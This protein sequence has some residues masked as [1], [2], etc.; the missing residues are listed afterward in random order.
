MVFARNQPRGANRLL[1]AAVVMGVALRSAQYLADT[2][3][4]L[5]EIALVKG[6]L[7]LD[8]RELVTES[9]PFDQV[10]PIGFL[11]AQKGAIHAFGPS[12]SALRLIPFVSS[13]VALVVF[14][15]FVERQLTSVAALLATLLFATAA[16][17][18]AF[19]GTA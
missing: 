13:V 9:L 12:D 17:F 4:W 6:I 16:P 19:A 11:V 10:A 8:L 5:D 18:I 2:S 1:L 14:S 3:L 7:E 15:R